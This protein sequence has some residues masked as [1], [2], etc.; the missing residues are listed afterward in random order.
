LPRLGEGADSGTVVQVLVKEG[1]LIEKD[2]P[3]IELENEKAVASIPATQSGT[4]E[5]IHVSEGQEIAAGDLILSLSTGQKKKEEAPQEKKPKAEKEPEREEE[6]EEAEAGEEREEEAEQK[7]KAEA[8][9]QAE[10]KPAAVVKPGVPPPAAPSVRKIA[11]D[12]GID[13]R[14]VR[15]SKRG[16]RIVMRDLRK[17]I[18]QLQKIAFE[19][20]LGPGREVALP[21]DFEQWG[22]VRREAMSGVR[23]AVSHKMEQAWASVPHVT[24]FHEA[25]ITGLLALKE[26]YEPAYEEKG[27]RL[28]LTSFVLKALGRV[29]K[30]RP[31]FNASLDQNSG[32]IVYKDYIHIGVAV[33]TEYG[34]VVPV[35]RD[36]DKRS[37]FD[38]SKDLEQLGAKARARKLS[39]DAMRGGS[40]TLSNQGG[41][42]GG[43]FT[44]IINVPE[45]A[46]LG[47]ARSVKTPVVRDDKIEPRV[48]LPL[49]LSYD[50]RVIAGASAVHFIC[51]LVDAL[52][53]FSE[54]DV[55]PQ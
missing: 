13:L 2:Q 38:L 5:R 42:G 35:I 24:Q 10:E 47:V 44:P 9:E 36:V 7:A 45:V 27:T 19:E 14:R 32:Q 31:I 22:P 48:M 4:V 55:K 20:K 28:T 43:N 21:L 1:D 52:E 40:F 8:D 50:H 54:E 37:M 34:L 39:A 6:E 25:D 23:K 53:N 49:A 26:K 51:A 33:D 3:I 16:G 17:Y 41:M 30:E 29:L 11:H 15:G 12:L 18:E 46:I